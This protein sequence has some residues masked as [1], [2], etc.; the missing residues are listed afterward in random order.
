MECD[1]YVR[2]NRLNRELICGHSTFNIYSLMLR[3]HK[4]YF[5]NFNNAAVANFNMTFTSRPGDLQ[6]KDDFYTLDKNLVVLETSL[7]NYNSS[8]YNFLKNNTLP[9]WIRLSVANRLSK[10][11]AEWA[12]N[13]QFQR[14]GTHNNQWLIVDYNSFRKQ[15]KTMLF[16]PLKNIVLMIEESFYLFSVTDM[17][18]MLQ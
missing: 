18:S 10:T 16:K 5:F 7:N 12:K 2:F 14:S 11:P 3:I 1:A 4:S 8:N 15:R 17:T 9:C 13:F 6:S